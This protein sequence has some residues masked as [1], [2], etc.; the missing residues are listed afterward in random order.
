MTPEQLAT[1]A[2]RTFGAKWQS[3][4]AKASGYSKSYISHIVAGRR[5]VPEDLVKLLDAK[6]PQR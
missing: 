1:K 4:L 5:K 2:R 3:K 6:T